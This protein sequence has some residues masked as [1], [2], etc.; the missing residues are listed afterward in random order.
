MHDPRDHLIDPVRVIRLPVVSRTMRPDRASRSHGR[1]DSR[2]RRPRGR[3]GALAIALA[4]AMAIASLMGP[5]SGPAAAQAPGYAVGEWNRVETEHFLFLY[6]TELSEWALDMAQRMEA[7]H[8]AVAALVGFAPEDRVTVVVDDPTNVSN[9]SMSPG[10][11]LFMW[12]TPPN[13]RSMIGEHRGWGELLAVHE[14][15]H[16]AHLTI[17]TRN[18]RE[19]FIH[20]L[21]PIP[22]HPIMR[23]TPRWVTEGYATY[24]EGRLTGHGRPHGVWRPAVLRTWALEGQLPTYRGMSGSPAFMGGAM[25]YLV[26]SAYLEWLV[27]REGDDEDVLPNVWR[28]LTARQVRS[29][30]AAFTG[31]FGQPAEELYGL[32]MVDLTERALAVRAAV[33]AAGGV[34]DGELFQ[35]LTWTTGDPAVSPDGEHLAVVLRSRDRPSRVVV[36]STTPDTLTTAARERRERIFELDPLDVEPVDR[37]PR[38]QRARATLWP[39]VGRAYDL[40][41]F[42]PDGQGIL[43]VRSDVVEGAQARPDLFLWEWERDRL[44]RVTWGEAVREASPA[45]D[46]TWAV[47]TRC[48]HSRCDLVRI[49][50]ASGAVS[51]LAAAEMLRPY[52]RPR[53]SPD[54]RTIVAS[55][56][57][58]NGWRL[59]AMDADGGNERLLGPD[60]G[61]ARFDAAFLPGGRSLVLTS[62]RGGIHDLEILDLETGHVRPLTRVVGAAVAPAPAPDGDVFFLSLHSRGWDL[63]RIPTTTPAPAL[64]E[65][66]PALSPAA[67]VGPVTVDTFPA[68]P[69]GPVEPYGLGPRFR[70]LLPVANFSVDGYGG[71]LSL[72]GTDPLGRLSWQVQALHGSGDAARGAGARVLWRG[73]RPWLH[74]GLFLLDGPFPFPAG[75]DAFPLPPPAPAPLDGPAAAARWA[76]GTYYGGVASLELRRTALGFNRSVRAGGSLGMLDGDESRAVGFAEYHLGLEQQVG[77]LRFAQ[78]GQLHGSVG[79]TGEL[80]WLRWLAAGRLEVRARRAGLALSGTIGGT[81]APVESVEAF[82]VG[83]ADPLLLDPGV[84]A[85]RVA[86]PALPSGRLRGDA[87][88]TARVD[89]IGLLPVSPFFWTGSVDGDELGW[90]HVAGVEVEGDAEGM[91]YLRLPSVRFR[92]GLARTLSE[93]DR[94]EWRGW[95]IVGYRP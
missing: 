20:G 67:P 34:V 82:A 62:S 47:G 19:R 41:E 4:V 10:P 13:P 48:L 71:G 92:L 16:A 89:L 14:F 86:M 24:V 56:Q 33:E 31:V 35:R 94:G 26:G 12:P 58:D 54:G 32:F 3:T 22:V 2:P 40:P 60:D 93:P 65:V 6:P 69:I 21:I 17:P 77:T 38:A 57:V 51:T 37:L 79:R 8:G 91:P 44:R 63:R 87:V 81:D 27:E 29:F 70:T 18:P 84:V 15:A 95:A 61:A 42:M 74:G 50:L 9:G 23:R 25:A 78:R 90:H 28:R 46:G 75:D 11:L 5:A 73:T 45:P 53:V 80:D 1:A 30:D 72:G 88:R 59:V 85:Q 68:A 39:A 43:V 7:V 76:D 66:D 49:D 83:G 55:V 64:V 52:Y 36:M